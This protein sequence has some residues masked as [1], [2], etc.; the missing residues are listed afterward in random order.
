[1]NSVQKAY[2]YLRIGNPIDIARSIPFLHLV[3]V[4]TFKYLFSKVYEI[5]NQ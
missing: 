4:R 3:T 1:M 2:R 5:Y